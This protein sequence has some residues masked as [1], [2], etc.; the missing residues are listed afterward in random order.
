VALAGTDTLNTR[1][2]L[3]VEGSEYDYYSLAAAE[4][5]GLGSL[6]RLPFSLKVLLENML[7]HE[8]GR[9]VTTDDAEAA[10][11]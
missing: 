3:Q 5:N 6:D 11:A 10:H 8:D 9:T 2:T 1:R 7:R 4:A